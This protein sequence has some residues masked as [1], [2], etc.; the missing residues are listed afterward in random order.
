MYFLIG[1]SLLFTFLIIS[2]VLLA[3]ITAASWR[4]L[5]P[6]CDTVTPKTGA[7]LLFVLRIMP[8]AVSLV[9]ILAFILPAFLLYEPPTR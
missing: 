1:A 7:G 9:F 8:I 6:I 5:E 4:L 3:V 2:S